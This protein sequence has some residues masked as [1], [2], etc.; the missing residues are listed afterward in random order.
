[1]CY[2]YDNIMSIYD[3]GDLFVAK[4]RCAAK[5]EG[6]TTNTNSSMRHRNLILDSGLSHQIKYLLN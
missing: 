5:A 2:V 6:E 3:R 1:M 4:P